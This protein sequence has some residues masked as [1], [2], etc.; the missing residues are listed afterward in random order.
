MKVMLK[1]LKVT[2]QL[3]LLYKRRKV[4][5]LIQG[6]VDS[7]YVEFLDSRKPVSGYIFTLYGGAIS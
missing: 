5:S 4:D 7:D 3:E 6:Y 1:Y 2:V